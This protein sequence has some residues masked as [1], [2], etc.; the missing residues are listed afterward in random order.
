MFVLLGLPAE[1]VCLDADDGENLLL[2]LS[3]FSMLCS[4]LFFV[5][6]T[7]EGRRAPE[8]LC[9]N[10]LYLSINLRPITAEESAAVF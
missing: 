1:C 5:V 2:S 8:A 3:G 7:L 9:V 4:S 6:K 10:D